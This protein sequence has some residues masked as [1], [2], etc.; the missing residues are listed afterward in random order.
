MQKYYLKSLMRASKKLV[1][2]GL[3]G[4]LVMKRQSPNMLPTINVGSFLLLIHFQ[5]C[6]RE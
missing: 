3:N 5:R 4:F 1:Q 6:L 2:Q